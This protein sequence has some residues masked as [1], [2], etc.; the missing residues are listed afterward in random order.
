MN[1]AGDLERDILD[2]VDRATLALIDVPNEA[3]ER[4]ARWADPDEVRKILRSAC[5]PA[6]HRLNEIEA[7]LSHGRG[8]PQGT[9]D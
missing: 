2:C 1:D 8:S 5:A 6:M 9:H 7:R 3:A 4:M